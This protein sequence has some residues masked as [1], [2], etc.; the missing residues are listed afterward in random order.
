MAFCRETAKSLVSDVIMPQMSGIEPSIAVKEI[1]SQCKALL[2]S[3]Q[4][5]T[6]DLPLDARKR[7]HEFQLL[8]KPAHPTDLL[9]AIR[10][11]QL[12]KAF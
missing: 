12:L 8:N 9:A 3:G 6:A 2:F 11:L 4:A 10:V 1:C 7:G 5:A